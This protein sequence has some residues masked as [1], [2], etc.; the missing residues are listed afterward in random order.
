MSRTGTVKTAG[1]AVLLLVGATAA[2][3]DDGDTDAASPD[4][5]G[6]AGA[7]DYEDERAA[8]EAERDRVRD[9]DPCSL[10]E[11]SEIE[12]EV[13]ELTENGS[14]GEGEATGESCMWQYHADSD[15][16][17][18]EEGQYAQVTRQVAHL[19]HQAGRSVMDDMRDDIYTEAVDVEGIGDD[20]FLTEPGSGTLWFLSG[21]IILSVH[22]PETGDRQAALEALAPLVLGRI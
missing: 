9:I 21:E 18:D 1:L 3:G 19:P 16:F 22:V 13:P 15:S 8:L 10:L 5:G 2:C 6:E 17:F 7:T 4:T 14:L 11:I 20:A 12:A